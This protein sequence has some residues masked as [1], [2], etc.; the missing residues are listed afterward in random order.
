MSSA[1]TERI[2]KVLQQS[3]LLQAR[4]ARDA[5]LVV[6]RNREGIKV[7]DVVVEQPSQVIEHDDKDMILSRYHDLVKYYQNKYQQVSVSS[8]KESIVS[9][10]VATLFDFIAF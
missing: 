3:L 1:P 10:F 5:D 4:S 9:I 8:L 7:Q 6:P 2:E